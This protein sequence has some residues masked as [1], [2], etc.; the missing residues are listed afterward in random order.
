MSLLFWLCA[1]LVVFAYAGYPALMFLYS[2]VRPKPIAKSPWLPTVTVV[3]SIY[4][5]EALA[6]AKLVNLL[7]LDYPS[8]LLDIVVMCDGCTDGTADAC[9]LSGGQRVTV[10][11]SSERRGKARGLDDA[12]AAATGEILLMTD[13][14][15][16]IELPALRELVDNFSDGSVGAVSGELRF[17]KAEGDF[18]GSVDAYWQ[19]E[20]AIRLAESKSG[21]VVG[22]TGAFY[23]MRRSLYEPLPEGTVLDDVLI[24][25]RIVKNG[26]RV[27]MDSY[28][29]AWDQPSRSEGQERLRKIRTL[30]GNYQLIALAPWL[31]SP[32]ANPLWFR[33]VSHKLLRLAA[34]WLILLILLTTTLLAPT[35]PFHA[36]C[37]CAALAC[38]AL[39]WGGQRVAALGR[40]M[41]VKLLNA[42]WYMNLYSAQALIAYVRNPRLHL[43]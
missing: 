14:R 13:V 30:A 21:S 3:M 17:E 9:R 16:R 37:L 23:A 27:V 29:V 12:V 5:G 22:V 7:E 36:L 6:A 34:P 31:V 11:E 20:K 26:F 1:V 18:S 43:W 2:Q 38:G 28:A 10:L 19:Y 33:F 15:Q 24:P 32:L 25:M 4:N 39:V 8:E 42:F 41:P 40:L 35:H